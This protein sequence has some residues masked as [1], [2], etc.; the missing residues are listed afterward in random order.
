LVLSISAQKRAK[1]KGLRPAW[2]LW[3]RLR[4]ARRRALQEFGPV[5]SVRDRSR[6][7]YTGDRGVPGSYFLK[8]IRPLAEFLCRSYMLAQSGGQR[9]RMHFLALLSTHASRL[10]VLRQVRL[11]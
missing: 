8:I 2:I 4:V 3:K 11:T 10:N 1:R 9:T 6:V 5:G 7:H